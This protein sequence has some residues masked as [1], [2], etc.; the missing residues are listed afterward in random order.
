VEGSC[1]RIGRR[2]NP[3][4]ADVARM[5]AAAKSLSS[6]SDGQPH[7]ALPVPRHHSGQLDTVRHPTQ[8]AARGDFGHRQ[9]APLIPK[10]GQPQRD[11]RCRRRPDLRQQDELLTGHA[12]VHHSLVVDDR[13]PRPDRVQNAGSRCRPFESTAQ[14]RLLLTTH[15]RGVPTPRNGTCPSLHRT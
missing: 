4:S 2:S 3:E 1:C 7:R 12:A 14:M 8:R 10:V 15:E 6:G 13:R 5:A 9:R 11:S